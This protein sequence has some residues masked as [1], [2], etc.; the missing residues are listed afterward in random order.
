MTTT[1]IYGQM[2]DEAVVIHCNTPPCQPEASPSTQWVVKSLR[3]IDSFAATDA[4]TTQA[5]K[6]PRHG[7]DDEGRHAFRG[8]EEVTTTG[9]SGSKTI[10]RYGYD[11]D[12]SGRL[13]ETVVRPAEAPTEARSITR[14]TWEPRS[15]FGGSIVTY[16][17]TVSEQLTC[18]NGQ[19]DPADTLSTPCTPTTAAGYTKT[20]STL[21]DYHSHLTGGGPALLWQE[22]GTL[23]EALPSP[24]HGDRSTSTDFYVYADETN[25]RVRALNTERYHGSSGAM[26]LY[27]K[28]AQTWDPTYRV[29]LTDETWVDSVDA[30]RAIARS[31]YDMATGNVIQRWKPVQNAAN[32][33]STTL[34]YD[35]RKLFVA[36]EVNEL[37]H[38]LDY[39]WE[40]GTGTK[41]RTDGPNVRS[42]VTGPS[43]P[44]DDLRPLK[45]Q[46]KI[47]I[48]GL[49]RTL[50]RWDT[51]SEDG[52][53][54]TLY[55]RER[56][57]YVDAVVPSAPASITHE[58][59]QTTAAN[60]PWIIEQT[61]L[62]GHGRPI[63]KI[64]LTQGSA[65][66][67]HITSFQYRDDGT[68]AVA[69]VPDPAKKNGTVSY[70]YGF[71][72]LGRPTSIR[73]PDASEPADRSGLDIA[74]DG[75]THTTTEVVGAGAGLAATTTT[76]TDAYGRLIEV[77]E[78]L[79]GSTWATTTY[80]HGADDLVE[81]II[82][83]EL[84]T[85]SLLHDFV[86]RRTQITRHGRTW[87]YGYDRNGNT[88]SEQTPCTPIPS[89]TANH[90]TTIAYDALDRP[91]SK[92]LA[93]RGLS[94]PDL[95]QFG[96][97]HEI[98]TWDYGSNMKGYLR[99]WSTYAPGAAA[100]NATIHRHTR[101]TSQGERY[102]TEHVFKLAG[103]PTLTRLFLQ[104][105]H[106]FGGAAH[107][108]YYDS[109]GGTAYTASD[110]NYDARGLPQ[111]MTLQWMNAGLPVKTLAV[112]ERN[113]AGLVTKRR[114]NTTGPMTFVESNWTYDTLGRV[115]SQVVR[116]GPGSTQVARQ[117][118]TYF[119]NDDPKTLTH[120]LG[121][122]SQQL[123]FTYDRRH[124]LTGVASTTAGYFTG[125]YA[126]G[127]AGR[128][129]HAAQAQTLQPPPAGSE[130]S[131]RDV[132]YIYGGVDPEQV[133][134]L[135]RVSDG[136]TYASYTY[137]DAGNQTSRTD[138]ATGESFHYVYD[139]KDQL[140]RATKQLNGAT[141]GSEE[142]W[143]D[144]DGQRVAVVRRDAT[145]NQTELIWFIGDVQAH[146]D[147]QGTIQHVYSHLSLG[148]PVA[149]VK[150]TGNTSTALELQF[151]GLANN[152][153]A[154][155]AEDGTINASFSYA[156]FGE[157]LEATNA[158]G[159]GAGTAAHKR[160]FNDKYQDDLT[161]LT[162][163]GARYYD[164]TLIGW[165]QADPMYRFAPDA[166]WIE[167]RRGNLYCFSG[168][169]P[170][171]YLDPDGL[172]WSR[173]VFSSVVRVENG[174]FEVGSFDNGLAADIGS[175]FLRAALNSTPAGRVITTV[176]DIATSNY[177][178]I[179]DASGNANLDAL[180]G[181]G[182]A[183]GGG[184]APR[185][186]KTATPPGNGPSTV[187]RGGPTAQDSVGSVPRSASGKGTVDAAARDPKRLFSKKDK[188]EKLKEQGGACPGCKK[189]LTASE[190]KGHH[191]QRHADGGKTTQDNHVVVCETCHKEVH[192]TKKE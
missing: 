9:P 46:H 191:K 85:T 73:R 182:G 5:Y 132:T 18:A 172:D 178:P 70:T 139:G 177:E 71:D 87:A 24:A 169:N 106:L 166:A 185:A 50:E 171:R 165:T 164:K 21:K 125:S 19:T 118:L 69:T 93:P 123:A 129:T 14:T 47:H 176:A 86:G 143:Y 110:I 146:Y 55:H 160:R 126:Y 162:Y 163:Y 56:T 122:A 189:K 7:A 35:S 114:T 154:A 111:S 161:A 183:P 107:A 66:A 120:A 28:S 175:V 155:V 142:Y 96:A 61:K 173:D 41:L 44:L 124:Q 36:T 188:S 25:Y 45:Q 157:V 58:V 100:S 112:Q 151:H 51:V 117:D 83:P 48:D 147:G 101:N 131:P 59:R 133:T 190:G 119:G 84:V 186:G 10:Q 29:P 121:T 34:T 116:K 31:A 16:H 113:V 65:S 156:P 138:P 15:L 184:A 159:A 77:R 149:R 98:Y 17:A 39:F 3:T 179:L 38:Q 57:A 1:A 43:C 95:A 167:P 150:R 4:T 42:C 103:F 13:V 168:N 105:F 135:T 74:Y 94:A 187:G 63:Q 88:V 152:T 130:V 12:W 127:P 104:R 144:G 75:V 32:G 97:S 6:H 141:Q 80:R 20:T 79:A 81:L 68:L 192:A 26:V 170:L 78:Q 72:S 27:G 40:Y 91:A 82:D 52:S 102:M 49:G 67:D 153:L 22:I 62:D 89:C 108:R 53:L 90:L 60:S 23:T 54:Y 8:F 76:M 137:D 181:P 180:G 11:V 37:G 99:Y 92:M 134:A 30:H 115:A 136:S 145:G 109:I 148:T 64:Q 128:L 2:H 158:G 33:P 174:K 140:R